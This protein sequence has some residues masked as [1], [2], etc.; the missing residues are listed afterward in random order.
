VSDFVILIILIIIIFIFTSFS[1]KSFI[2]SNGKITISFL[3]GYILGLSYP[4]F[5]QSYVNL[6]FKQIRSSR[7]VQIS[8]LLVLLF[9][10]I[11]I[12]S[13][14]YL[15]INDETGS[16][17]NKINYAVYFMTIILVLAGLYISRKKSENYNTVKYF[18]SNSDS[19]MCTNR[20][21]ILQTSGDELNITI[22]FSVFI[23]LLLFSYEPATIGWKNLYSF[24]YALLLGILVSSV[25]YFGF[26]YFLEKTPQKE[27]NSLE[28]CKFK[29]MPTPDE[30]AFKS[31][32][33]INPKVIDINKSNG[34]ISIVNILL[35]I[36]IVIVV[37]YLIY[38]YAK[39]K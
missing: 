31:N 8:Y 1:R 33:P 14:N 19:Q 38:H 32:E 15:S 18:Y 23:L 5:I 21:G 36:F 34:N 2:E 26:E 17:K 7:I 24:V 29:K 9:F 20:N 28:E 3:I 27:C 35:L 16:S 12:I 22:P 13:I 6:Y 11:G 39:G 30:N 10:A 37:F 4:V 25:S